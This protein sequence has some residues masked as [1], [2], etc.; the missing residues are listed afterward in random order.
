MEIFCIFLPLLYP[1]N[2]A[3]LFPV[4]VLSMQQFILVLLDQL[5]EIFLRQKQIPVFL[6]IIKEQNNQVTLSN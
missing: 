6:Q 1:S 4:S 3:P 2:G 5:S